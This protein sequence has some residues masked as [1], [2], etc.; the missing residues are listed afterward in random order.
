[1]VKFIIKDF[2]DGAVDKNPPA[3]V[4]DTGLIPGLGRFHMP[5]SN[6]AHVPQLLSLSAAA[7][8]ACVPRTCVLQREAKKKKRK[9]MYNQAASAHK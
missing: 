5:W 1:M 9:T 4:G 6:Q 7:T 8:E 2:L 3:N